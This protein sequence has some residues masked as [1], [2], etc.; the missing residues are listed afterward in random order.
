MKTYVFTNRVYPPVG[1]ATGVLLKELAE[2]LAA[3]GARVVVVTSKSAASGG[4]R[5][6]PQNKEVVNGVEVIR[7]GSAPFTRSS[8]A[9]RALSYLGLYPQFAWQ[10]RRLGAVD[11]VVS[12]TDPPLQVAPVTLAS[13]KAR[14]RV[15]WAQD[16]YPELAEE[17]G[18]IGRG[19]VLAR[20]LRSVSTRALRRQDEVVVVGRCMRGRLVSRGIDAGKIEVIPN[21]IPFAPAPAGNPAAVRERLGWRGKFVALYS[22]N[23]GLAHDFGT[24]LAAAKILRGTGVHMVFAGEGPR[25]TEIRRGAEGL[26]N[27]SFLPPQPGQD[28]GAFLE[29]ADIHL[30][31]VRAGLSGLVVPSKLYGILAAGRPAVY[32]GPRDSEAA[33]V[34]RDTGAGVVA[35]NGDA[36]AVASAL[37]HAAANP[38]V[39]QTMAE[40]ARVAARQFTFAKALEK[41]HEVLG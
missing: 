38:G 7:V 19:G 34:L 10:V 32:T 37:Q 36:A 14:K 2:G 1:G 40:A 18:V 39:V 4:H 29:A 11:A 41:W 9:R 21:W 3:G 15:H 33:F 28:L 31:T 20:L 22:G 6:P 27:V 17:L 13:G 30:V 35:G 23:L 24:L 5:A 26:D 12:M 25:I 8:H 16:V